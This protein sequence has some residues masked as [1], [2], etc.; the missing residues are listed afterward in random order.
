MLKQSFGECFG[1]FHFH[2]SLHFTQE[3]FLSSS[4]P[5]NS[6]LSHSHPV[7][8]AWTDTTIGLFQRWPGWGSNSASPH[9]PEMRPGK[10]GTV[11]DPHLTPPHAH[12]LQ[13]QPHL[14]SQPGTCLDSWKPVLLLSFTACSHDTSS[15][16]YANKAKAEN[17]LL[18]GWGQLIYGRGGTGPQTSACKQKERT[19]SHQEGYT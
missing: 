9:L 13:P 2:V 16:R 8:K 19:Q 5:F 1:W 15:C 17:H 6:H 7:S 10:R 18:F 12:P 14:Y 4:D 3:N 11:P